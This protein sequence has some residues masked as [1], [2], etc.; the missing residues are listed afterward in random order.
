MFLPCASTKY[1]P[2]APNIPAQRI[3]NIRDYVEAGG[4]WYA[5]D[6]SNEYIEG[7]F[8]DYQ[9]FHNPGM[10]DIQ[11]AY[12]SVGTVVEPELLA[13]LEA[14][15]NELKDIGGNN[16]TLFNLPSITTDKN[17]SGIDETPEVWVED[18]GGNDVNVGHRTWVEGP[19][20]SCTNPQ[21]DRPMA[22]SGQYGCGRM[23]Y[24][25]FETSSI[26][27]QGLNPQELVLLYMILEITTCFD[28][29][30]PPPPAN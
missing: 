17:Y 10:P 1:W 20:Q 30:P 21:Q 13:W 14:L 22:V 2:G 7:P 4:K 28:G 24:S 29:T 12:T 6:H 15:P 11:P 8:P 25:T 26:A 19:C 27:H 18:G 23:M 9:Q 3:Q 5:T 16:F